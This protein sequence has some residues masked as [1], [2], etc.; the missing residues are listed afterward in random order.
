VNKFLEL[1]K[2]ELKVY[3]R[4]HIA[5]FWTFLFPFF[6]LVIF[7]SISPSRDNSQATDVV[8]I[9]H[10]ASDKA[11]D[12]FTELEASITKSPVTVSFSSVSTFEADADFP[13]N[14]LRIA[15]MQDTNDNQPLL[16]I[17]HASKP[18]QASLVL[19]NIIELL[20]GSREFQNNTTTNAYKIVIQAHESDSARS[21][22]EGAR[23]LTIGLICMSIMSTCFFGF[24]VVL[25]QLRAAN[26]LKM[27]QVMP[28]HKAIYSSA[29]MI[30]RVLIILIFAIVFIVI[31]DLLYGI[32]ITYT[33]GNFVSFIALVSIGAMT[34]ISIG[35]LVASRVSSVSAA[36]GIINVLYFPLV[37]LSGLFFPISS[38]FEWLNTIASYLP[39]KE[40]AEMFEQ[41]IFT[42]TS[43]LSF[44]ST[45]ILMLVWGGIPFLISQ[46]N[47]V[48]NADR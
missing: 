28:L 26:A 13:S 47:F 6:I 40:Y 15:L 17:T 4:D 34:F 2:I 23:S 18:T 20:A 16:Q 3:V 22:I 42:E 32:G 38:N 8:F 5:L 30:S 41:I 21:G 36:N 27:Y 11:R 43:F 10:D 39:L 37:F 9:E 14:Q 29:F 44:T 35:I 45:L 7:M 19:L 48:W 24:S 33:F 31:A 25:V 1:V 12:Y 46:S